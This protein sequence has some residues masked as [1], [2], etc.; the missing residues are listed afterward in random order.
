MQCSIVKDK[1][2]SFQLSMLRVAFF[3]MHR[4]GLLAIT[5]E[6]YIHLF[7]MLHVIL[8]VKKVKIEYIFCD[9]VLRNLYGCIYNIKQKYIV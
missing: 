9:L 2:L 5:V 1:D 3:L 8:H 6:T 4:I 7:S